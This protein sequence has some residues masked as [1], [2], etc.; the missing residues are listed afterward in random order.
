MAGLFGSEM[1]EPEVKIPELD[2]FLAKLTKAEFRLLFSVDFLYESEEYREVVD[3]SR[4]ATPGVNPDLQGGL[5]WVEKLLRAARWLALEHGYQFEHYDIDE[6]GKFYSDPEY[7]NDAMLLY[8]VALAGSFVDY[9][10]CLETACQV[11]D[12]WVE[13]EDSF[14]IEVFREALAGV[15]QTIGEVERKAMKNPELFAKYDK[16]RDEALESIG[17]KR[18]TN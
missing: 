14:P 4:Y 17:V 10:I 12:R 13:R 11:L 3:T 6:E 5:P 16:A 1:V 9:E 8:A 2:R 7:W 18:S 15:V